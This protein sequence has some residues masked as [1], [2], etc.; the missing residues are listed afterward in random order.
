[1]SEPETAP[2]S[3][4]P[5]VRLRWAWWLLAWIALALAVLG[6]V[7][8]GL[9]AVPFVL[10]SAFAAA[11]GSQR[12][13]ARLLADPRSGPMIRDWQ[14]HGAVSRR[15]KWLAT[16]MMAS[17]GALLLAFASRKWAAIGI[18]WMAAVAL[19]LWLRPE[20]P[21]SPQVPESK[22]QAEQPSTRSTPSTRRKSASVD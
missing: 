21:S 9:P 12:L 17:S 20:R 6:V 16:L 8:P 5:R 10:L 4:R 3:Q 11:R 19:W 13:H 14:A 7:L 2:A 15:S 1:M 22:A 18:A